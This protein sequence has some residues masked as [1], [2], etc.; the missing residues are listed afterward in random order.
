[1]KGSRKWWTGTVALLGTVAVFWVW[2][3]C[4][5]ISAVRGELSNI[6]AGLFGD[7]IFGLL[8]TLGWLVGGKGAKEW[9]TSHRGGKQ[10]E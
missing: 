2:G 10:D 8:G 5:V 1:M 4:F 7:I 6:E 9:I 3:T